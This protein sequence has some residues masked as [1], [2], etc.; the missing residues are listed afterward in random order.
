[1]AS[2]MS[3]TVLSR[4]VRK[5]LPGE[6]LIQNRVFGLSTITARYSSG[7]TQHD[8]QIED[9]D[10]PIPYTSSGALKWTVDESLGSRHQ[11]PKWRVALIS[12]TLSAI[13]IWAAFREETEI[14]K[15]LEK[16]LE[17]RMAELQAGFNAA[18]RIQEKSDNT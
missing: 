17:Q 7:K 4:F 18:K 14:D 3:T 10:K 13:L 15:E 2:S 11:Q 9:D 12:V 8:N 1:M 6:C 5:I 16:P